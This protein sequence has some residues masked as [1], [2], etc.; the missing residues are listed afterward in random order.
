MSVSLH[1]RPQEPNPAAL[2]PAVLLRCYSYEQRRPVL[3]A[4]LGAMDYCGCWIADKQAMS[5][6]QIEFRFEVQLCV[7]EELYSELIGAGVEMSRDS[8]LA[9]TWLCTRMRHE[10]HG[11]SSGTVHIRMEM[12]FLEE[13]APEPGMMAT[14]HA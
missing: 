14:G 7:V 8:H 13:Y 1:P 12:S 10:P 4:L 3:A 6:T 11:S 9:M 2:A 5:S